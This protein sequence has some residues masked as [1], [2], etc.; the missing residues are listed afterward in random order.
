MGDE[1]FYIVLLSNSSTKYYPN[2]ST[3]HF[4]TKLPRHIELTGQWSV[5]LVDIH[6]P[7]TFSTVPK[8]VEERRVMYSR[9]ERSDPPADGE[10]VLV[11]DEG[12]FLISPGV[13]S[14]LDL[15]IEELNEYS[16]ETHINFSLNNG[17]YVR[18]ETVCIGC[19]GKVHSFELSR[20]LRRIL[21]FEDG[22]TTKF[23]LQQDRVDGNTPGDIYSNVP[24][25]LLVYADICQPYITG[26]VYTRLL[27]NVALDQTLYR[28]GG[29]ASKSFSQPIYVPLICPTFETI[30][31][32]IRSPTGQTI[33][34]DYGTLT[35]TLHFR[36]KT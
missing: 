33:P 10:V 9:W 3:G 16:E 22:K 26:D 13:Y 7:L 25:N 18:A 31:I 21:G 27:R 4:V 1:D 11:V 6:I 17:S 30:E 34:F 8:Q 23:D 35:V 12:E 32:D 19:T 5:A 36:K 20:C 2:N 15:L 28:Y 29:I 24:T 14:S